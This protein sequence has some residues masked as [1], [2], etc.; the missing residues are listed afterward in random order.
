MTKPRFSKGQQIFK[1]E[2]HKGE[3]INITK[4]IVKSC[5]LKQ[6]KIVSDCEFGNMHKPNRK[7]GNFNNLVQIFHSTLNDAEKA[8]DDF[9]KNK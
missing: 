4:E 6:L 2:L 8:K 7:D 1:I 9:Y 5:G 3:I